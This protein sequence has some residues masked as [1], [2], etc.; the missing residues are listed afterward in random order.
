LIGSGPIVIGQA[1]EFDYSG[2][3]ACRALGEEG[4]RVVL[5]NSNPATIMTDPSSADQVYLE[6][7]TLEAVREVIARERPDALLPTIGGQ[8][9]LNLAREL[10]LQGVLD[11]FGVE[12]IGARLP[13]IEA[14]EDREKFHALMLDHEIAV[15]RG[16]FARDMA[17]ARRVTAITGFPVIVR[18]AYTL[19]GA[20]SGVA[21]TSEEFEELAARGLGA[22]PIGE[23]LIEESVQ[24]WKEFELEVM[25]DR[26]DNC[27]VVCSIEN[28]D[29]MGIHTG[30]SMTV[31]PQQTLT[32]QEY[33]HMRDTAFRVIRAVGV[34]TGG[35]NI[36]FAVDP[37]T[38]RQLV[39]EMNPR[40]SRSSA[41]ASKATGFPI[42]KIAARLAVGY[43]L[44][45]IPNDITGET[46]ASFEPTID[47]IVVKVPRFDFE[48]FPRGD[49][50]LTT[51]MKSVGETMAI[52]RT[53][54]EALQKGLRGLETGTTGAFAPV[55]EDVD[56]DELAARLETAS[57]V[58][59]YQIV[60]ALR[61]GWPV[62]R[63][64]VLTAFDPWFLHQIRG[65]VRADEE[66][67]GL[68]DRVGE[69]D[70]DAWRRIKVAGFSD[71]HLARR[72]GE[73]ESDVRARREALDVRP[74]F[75]VVDTCAGEFAARTPYYYSSYDPHGEAAPLE[76]PTTL[77][78]GGGPNRI[79][80]GI[81]FDYCCVQA[82]LG[83]R[84]IGH[85]VIMVNCNPE[86]VSTDYDISD[87]LYFEPLT[88]ED[89]WAIVQH[90]KPDGV[91]VQY[92]GQTPLKLAVPLDR[93]GVPIIGTSPA[94][95]HRAEDRDEFAKLLRELEILQPRS[96]IA[97]TADEALLEARRIGYPILLRPSYVLGG[98]GMIVVT[99]E[100]ALQQALEETLRVSQG[101]PLLIDEFL[102]GAVEFDVDAIA[103]GERVVI[104]GVMQHIEEAGIH[105][106]DSTCVLPPHDLD[107][108]I[109]E[110][111]RATTRQLALALEVRG[112]VNVQYA[113]Q[114]D[115][116]Y[117]LEVNPRASRTIPFVSKAVGVPLARLG[118]Q[119]MAG[120]SLV[121]L[122]LVT[123]P[124]PV[125]VAVK[126]P[127]F[128]FG[129]FPGADPILGPEM[130]STGEVIGLAPDAP[131]AYVKAL[132]GAGI[133]LAR[134][135]E[136]GVLFSLNDRDKEVGADLAS[137]LVR[138]G[139][140]VY[141]TRGTQLG[142]RRH[143]VE[144][145]LVYKV[146]EATPNAVDRT[147]AGD[148]GL[149]VT[150]PVGRETRF[151]EFALRRAALQAGVPC[152]TT[153]AAARF[154]LQAL[155]G[156]DPSASVRS[157]QQWTVAAQS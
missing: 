106:G 67:S 105:S 119:V 54:G 4:Y 88:F 43:T 39:I 90:E 104:G 103:D 49:R 150:T 116:V 100:A 24:G 156:A 56:D 89:V 57:E 149:I 30:D 128:P 14:A 124:E 61:R 126:A 73:F 9:A 79:G 122:G 130:L 87:R 110:R 123:D 47:Y 23:I 38:G 27:V 18:P 132:A 127:V 66:L 53:F 20:G 60:E 83:L 143:G 3:Q 5:I 44:D 157:I 63:V 134:A 113:V 2:T 82:A 31:A 75:K 120:K 138:R 12:L 70:A 109:E 11:E 111:L 68:A 28:I 81:E 129:R 74:A 21:T 42:A 22:S 121:E 137:A 86:T 108:D 96:G 50:R 115:T 34:E 10:A 65:I 153:M 94:S 33:Q 25:R 131:T 26:A 32:D 91:L 58:R 142:F 147:L 101:H 97:R 98:R 46:P 41:L 154:G 51:S 148:F 55:W 7:L 15:P 112:L 84:E 76:G 151:E 72:W 71:A 118:A 155:E 141:A 135:I 69:L 136:R 145:E 114:G 77:I 59:I 78:L 125:A 62:E 37:A 52:G 64:R 16:Q 146:G 92:G 6:P 107:P 29:P 93:A 80:Q 40:V 13:A 35:S 85:R 48:K 144:A 139:V 95:I 117:V 102:E 17:Q 1:C 19:G 45:E 36:Q 140:P 99:G 8:T 133:D 152:I